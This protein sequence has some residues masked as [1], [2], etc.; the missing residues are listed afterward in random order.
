VRN[1]SPNPSPNP[2]PTCAALP[3]ARHNAK[4]ALTAAHPNPS[5]NPSPSPTQV[6]NAAC[7]ARQLVRDLV[8]L[9]PL[10]QGVARPP[11]PPRL[12][13]LLCCSSEALVGCGTRTPSPSSAPSPDSSP[14]PSPK[15][16]PHPSQAG[17]GLDGWQPPTA[18][19]AALVERA[20]AHV[21]ARRWRSASDSLTLALHT[22]EH[23]SGAAPLPPAEPSSVVLAGRA[24]L[25]S[26]RAEMRLLLRLPAAALADCDA[27]LTLCPEN[28]TRT[29][30][31]TRT[32]TLP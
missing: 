22:L 8:P 17:G 9:L 13:V 24:G 26:A 4:P 12:R 3:L 27:A 29:R 14:K 7:L 10:P 2:K 16:D 28:R 11:V 21:G 20:Q 32:L 19:C 31:R 1:P 25:L 5:P 15:H 6:R 23:G 30:T 18:Q